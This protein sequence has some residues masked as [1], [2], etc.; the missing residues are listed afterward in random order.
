MVFPDGN[1]YKGTWKNNKMH[2]KGEFEWQDGRHY[3]GE[4]L[5]DKK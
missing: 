4:Y 2:G 3:E 5:D 1:I